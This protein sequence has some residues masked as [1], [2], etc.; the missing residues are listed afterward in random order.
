MGPRVLL[1]SLAPPAVL[2]Q[3]LRCVKDYLPQAHVTALLGTSVTTASR[4]VPQ[5]DELL[6]WRSFGPRA[7]L[8]ELRRLRARAGS[9]GTSLRP[10][11]G[12]RCPPLFHLAGMRVQ[13]S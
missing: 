6:D 4:D 10:A 12:V 3:T 13:Q 5:P 2:A 8:A 7:L 9:G 1:I 11:D